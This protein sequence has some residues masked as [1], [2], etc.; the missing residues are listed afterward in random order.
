MEK[1]PAIL[2]VV[3]AL[4]L[5]IGPGAFDVV[6]YWPRDPHTVGIAPPGEQ[7]PCVCVLTAGRKPGRYDLEHGGQVFRDC[8]IEGLEWAVRH[9]LRKRSPRRTRRRT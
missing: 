3:E 9:E 1:S 6:D 4:Q 7:E 2:E 8:V 5:R